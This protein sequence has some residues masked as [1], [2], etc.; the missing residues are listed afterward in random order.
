[1]LWQVLEV[2]FHVFHLQDHVVKF[3]LNTDLLEALY[4]LFNFL[5]ALFL[6]LEDLGYLEE[7]HDLV[8][9]HLLVALVRLNIFQVNSILLLFSFSKFPRSSVAGFL[10]FSVSLTDTLA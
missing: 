4:E 8:G 9:P 1:M 2:L 6:F 5:G 7:L 3:V 10:L